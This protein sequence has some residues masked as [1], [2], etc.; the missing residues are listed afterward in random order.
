LWHVNDLLG[1]IPF[2][3]AYKKNIQHNF[4]DSPL[5]VGY[6]TG[7]DMM[8]KRAVLDEVGA[9]DKDFFMYYEE[10]ELS[11]RIKKAG[12]C[13]VALP[14]A[15]II[16]LEG[17]SCDTSDKREKMKSRS[18]KLYYQKT[19][20]LLAYYCANAMAYANAL[21]RMVYA[22]LTGDRKQIEYWTIIKNNL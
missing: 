5:A 16:H 8:V 12:Y 10:T 14:D 6:V 7:A 4:S 9:F 1:G 2:K 19:Q 11:Y 13:I 17:K 3:L 18:K 20:S 15:K 22:K 21:L